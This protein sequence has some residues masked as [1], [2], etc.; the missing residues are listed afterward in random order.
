ML[1]V[2]W[3]LARMRPRA[4]LS[5]DPE[6]EAGRASRTQEVTHFVTTLCEITYHNNNLKLQ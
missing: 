5:R 3:L 1:L 4:E 6:V 2:I